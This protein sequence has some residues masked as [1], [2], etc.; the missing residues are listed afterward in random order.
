LRLALSKGPNRVGVSLSPEDDN[1]SS[2]RNVEFYSF[3][4]AGRWTKSENP[5]ILS[6]DLNAN[7]A[8]M[9]Y[10]VIGYLLILYQSQTSVLTSW[11]VLYVILPAVSIT[12]T[13]LTCIQEVN[14]SNLSHDMRTLNV[15]SSSFI[16]TSP[17][18][19]EGFFVNPALYG[20]PKIRLFL[21]ELELIIKSRASSVGVVTAY[22]LDT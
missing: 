9:S 17:L 7:E 14:G 8:L 12:A 19:H 5:A 2:L 16:K 18:S 4:N 22:G 11:D 3:Q 10:D 1:R 15:L 21:N 20:V 6:I 13:P